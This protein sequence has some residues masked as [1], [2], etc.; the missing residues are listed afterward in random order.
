MLPRYCCK[1]WTGQK[2]FDNFAAWIPQRHKNA[3][4]NIINVLS[5][6]C[7]FVGN[8]NTELWKKFNGK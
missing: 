7:S 1:S 8:A 4:R 3:Q 2:A 6:L 5:G